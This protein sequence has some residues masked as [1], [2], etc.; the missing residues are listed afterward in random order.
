MAEGLK[1]PRER[2]NSEDAKSTPV[3]GV[4]HT[5]PQLQQHHDARSLCYKFLPRLPARNPHATVMPTT[6]ICHNRPTPLAKVTPSCQQS[7]ALPG[8]LPASA[9][10]G[11]APRATPA[12]GAIPVGAHAEPIPADIVPTTPAAWCLEMGG[13]GAKK[14]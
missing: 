6:A 14:R 9:A 13:R 7:A 11:S 5:H 2:K 10:S 8:P 12:P 4:T 1:R 3:A